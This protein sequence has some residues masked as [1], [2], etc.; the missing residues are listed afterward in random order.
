MNDLDLHKKLIAA[1]SELDAEQSEAIGKDPK[2]QQLLAEM[3][4]LDNNLAKA[5]SVD[6]PDDLA[7]KLLLK[8][9]FEQFRQE[10]KQKRRWS[11][12]MAASVIFTV[13]IGLSHLFFNPINQAQPVSEYALQHMFHEIGYADKVNENHSLAQVNA[14]LATFGMQLNQEVGHV[15]YANYCDLYGLKSLHLVMEG[16]NSKVTV[17]VLPKSE[18]TG[19]QPFEFKQYKGQSIRYD[20]ADI[21]MIGE[22]NESLEKLETKFNKNIEWR[23]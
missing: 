21:I 12:A 3:Q 2:K 23:I 11:L 14:K 8:Q 1:P 17:F 7:N 4:E 18:L 22:N 19:W 10:Q 13:S 6:V 5:M 15:Y 9:S 16:K 20:K